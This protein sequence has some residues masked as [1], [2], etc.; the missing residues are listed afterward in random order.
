MSFAGPNPMRDGVRP[1]RILSEDEDAEVRDWV[2]DCGFDYRQEDG[3]P[4]VLIG[5]K[6]TGCRAEYFPRRGQQPTIFAFYHG[7]MDFS[8][9]CGC[10]VRSEPEGTTYGLPEELSGHGLRLVAELGLET[11]HASMVIMK[12]FLG[13]YVPKP[14]RGS[15]P[16]GKRQTDEVEHDCEPGCVTPTSSRL[17]RTEEG[18]EHGM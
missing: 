14:L 10:L 11:K 6:H 17:Q 9:S 5:N 1:S 3:F 4:Q 18:G 13:L 2:Y 8:T 16:E 7:F 12:L 15:F